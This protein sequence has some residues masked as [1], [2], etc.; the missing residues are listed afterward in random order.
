MAIKIPTKSAAPSA[1]STKVTQATNT[2]AKSSVPASDTP[3]NT[4][5][6]EVSNGAPDVSVATRRR[7][8]PVGT[9]APVAASAKGLRLLKPALSKLEKAV[10]VLSAWDKDM[11]MA[12]DTSVV[13]LRFVTNFV[14]ELPADFK[15]PRAPSAPSYMPTIGET[16]VLRPKAIRRYAGLGEELPS[17]ITVVKILPGDRV[18]CDFGDDTKMPVLMKHLLPAVSMMT[19]VDA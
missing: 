6:L 12:L 16:V 10:R 11:A 1:P 7:G 14:T 4:T 2:Q 3:V 19:G 8:R 17:E 18:L 9:G 5:L 15:A 13:A